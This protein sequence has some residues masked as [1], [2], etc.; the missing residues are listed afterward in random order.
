MTTQPSSHKHLWMRRHGV[1]VRTQ[2]VSAQARCEFCHHQ[3][4]FCE[5]CHRDM[6]PRDHTTLFRTRTH[7]MVASVDRSR[8]QVCHQTDFCIRCHEYTSPRS[9]RGQWA[10]GRNTH[11]ITCHLPLAE[12]CAVCHKGVPTHDTAPP[13]PIG[14][15]PG[16]NCRACHFPGGPGGMPHIDNGTSCEICHN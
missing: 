2:G 7:G 14:H 5:D 1:M 10:R 13:L 16:S 4:A 12:N 3:P 15:A 11:C 8:C 6:E 9:H